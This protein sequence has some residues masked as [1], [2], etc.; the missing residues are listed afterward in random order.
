M[1]RLPDPHV[2]SGS[3][4]I[5]IRKANFFDEEMK[6]QAQVCPESKPVVLIMRGMDIDRTTMAMH[7][8]GLVYVRLW[9]GTHTFGLVPDPHLK[10]SQ[11]GGMC[12]FWSN[13]CQP[14][15]SLCDM[16]ECNINY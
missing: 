1:A 16:C 7:Y 3:D 2:I 8:D 5:V 12:T 9:I 10:Y 6:S 15:L 4:I 14:S 13:P 11:R